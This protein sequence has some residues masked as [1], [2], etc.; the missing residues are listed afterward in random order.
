[1]S[2]N[3]SILH[4]CKS[5]GRESIIRT[6]FIERHELLKNWQ[7]R[8]FHKRRLKCCDVYILWEL[9]KKRWLEQEFGKHRG[10]FVAH[11]MWFKSMH[12]EAVTEWLFVRILT[13][14]LLSKGAGSSWFITENCPNYRICSD[15]TEVCLC[16]WICAWKLPARIGSRRFHDWTFQQEIFSF[17]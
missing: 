16:E 11:Q 15:R 7:L 9:Q 1:M 14:W 13:A 4:L 3:D 2:W 12:S 10:A 8:N 17:F 5:G 6:E